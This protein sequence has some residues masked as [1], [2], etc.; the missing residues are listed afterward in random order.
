M[1]VPSYASVGSEVVV[2]HLSMKNGS[3]LE[4]I[5]VRHHLT[6]LDSDEVIT[7][8]IVLGRE[9]AEIYAERLQ[10]VAASAKY[11]AEQTEKEETV[12]SQ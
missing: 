11:I 7:A 8:D 10:E 5:V 3:D 4:V 2:G 6:P 1:S 9:D 12:E